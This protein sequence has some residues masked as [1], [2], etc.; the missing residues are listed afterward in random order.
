MVVRSSATA[1]D[2]KLAS[3]AGEV[4]VL[5]QKLIE[6]EVAGVVSV[7]K[8][9]NQLVIE[10]NRELEENVVAGKVTPDT[11]VVDKKNKIIDINVNI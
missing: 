9:K 11:Y 1:E 10:A 8:D 5:V 7:T 3:W 4:A 6:S 2:S